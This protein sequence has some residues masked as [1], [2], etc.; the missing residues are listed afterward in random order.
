MQHLLFAV[1]TV[2]E[3][4]FEQS[5]ISGRNHLQVAA[6]PAKLKDKSK[7]RSEKGLFCA[8]ETAFEEVDRPKTRGKTADRKCIRIHQVGYLPDGT[9]MNRAGNAI[10]HPETIGPD[11][12]APG[13]KAANNDSSKHYCG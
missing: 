9:P 2:F 11:P 6:K 12:H 13:S 5:P 7:L 3:L 10:N 1:V 8:A 4:V